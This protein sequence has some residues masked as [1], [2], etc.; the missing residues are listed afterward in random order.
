MSGKVYQ[1][2]TDRIV[3]AL[4][5]GVVP[6]RSRWSDRA[7]GAALSLSTGKAYRGANALM[8]APMVSGFNSPWWGTLRQ[9]NERG[10]R[11]RR[12]EKSSPCIFWKFLDGINHCRRSRICSL[13]IRYSISSCRRR[14]IFSRRAK[15]PPLMVPRAWRRA[16]SCS[17]SSHSAHKAWRSSSVMKAKSKGWRTLVA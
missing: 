3:A 10:G 5:R 8:L 13:P 2:V 15:S 4:E 6:W 17:F 16:S 1:I 7:G 9:V 14:I 12:G 11:V